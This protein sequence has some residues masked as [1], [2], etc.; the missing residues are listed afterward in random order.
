MFSLQ[1][2]FLFLPFDW[3]KFKE[4]IAEKSRS[5]HQKASVKKAILK[6]FSI[7]LGKHLCWSLF[8]IKLWAR[9]PPPTQLLSCEYCEIFKNIYF[10]EH[11]RTAGWFWR[12]NFL[13]YK[14]IFKSIVFILPVFI[15]SNNELAKILE[16]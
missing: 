12:R 8:S 1:R 13:M 2:V 15:N 6:N 5:S 11:L 14:L 7:F 10:E 16:N 9:P 4:Q 3:R